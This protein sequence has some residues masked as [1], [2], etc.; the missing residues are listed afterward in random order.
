MFRIGWDRG[1]QHTAYFLQYLEE[2]FG[3]GT[4]RRLNDK[5][6]H[7]KYRGEYFWLD[8]FG[9]SVEELYSDYVKS[10]E[11]GNEEGE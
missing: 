2:R 1:Y 9:Q 10:E 5:L 6:R 3:E 11:G 7:H 8:L 4:I